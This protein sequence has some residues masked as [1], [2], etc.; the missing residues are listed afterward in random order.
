MEK[1]SGKEK[2]ALAIYGL[3]LL[4]T[5]F[6]IVR[7]GN[8]VPTG[9]ETVV[10]QVIEKFDLSISIL[11]QNLV[12][13][14]VSS[15][16][17][18]NQTANRLIDGDSGSF[19]HVALDQRGQPAWVTVDF[20]EGNEKVVRSLAALPRGDIPHQFFRN[21]RFCGSDD[22]N[23]WKP[24]VAI[25]LKETPHRAS[26]WKWEFENSRAYRYYKLLILDGHENGEFYSIAE[27]AF[28]E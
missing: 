4:A 17:G 27:L 9:T 16:N 20:G 22:G 25:T 1:F 5:G 3:I 24:I 10:G 15:S 12:T 7:Q 13:L 26:W 6:W 11:K 2:A 19:W 21:A 14:S 28:F 18:V 8:L 23:N